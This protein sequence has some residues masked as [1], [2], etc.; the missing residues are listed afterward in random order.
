MPQDACRLL[1][2]VGACCGTAAVAAAKDILMD[3]LDM[4]SLSTREVR[5]L[6]RFPSITP[7]DTV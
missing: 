6:A 4:P 1:K 5:A 7:A 2:L 3:S